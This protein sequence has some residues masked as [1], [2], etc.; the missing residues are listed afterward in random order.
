MEWASDRIDDNLRWCSVQPGTVGMKAFCSDGSR[1]LLDTMYLSQRFLRRV[2]KN[3]P[4]HGV[5]AIGWK[6]AGLVASSP[7]EPLGMSLIAAH[8]HSLGVVD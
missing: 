4:I 1:Y 6:L 5:R 3:L 7:A 2:V 8:F